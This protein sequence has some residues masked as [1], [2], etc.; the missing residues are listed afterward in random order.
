MKSE[1]SEQDI[2]SAKLDKALREA[3]DKTERAARS[4]TKAFQVY[5]K[6]LWAAAEACEY[7]SLMYLLT[8]NLEGTNTPPP[9]KVEELDVSKALSQATLTLERI[10]SDRQGQGPILEGYKLLRRDADLL[11]SSYLSMTRPKQRS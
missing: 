11:R 6:E 5:E 9:G 3:R 10:L 2:L 1:K 4:T 7:A 8:Y